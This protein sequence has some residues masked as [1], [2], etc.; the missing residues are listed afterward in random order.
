M[1]RKKIQV[2]WNEDGTK[3][4]CETCKGFYFLEEFHYKTK[5]EGCYQKY[6]EEYREANREVLAE[7]KKMQRQARKANK[8]KSKIQQNRE[9]REFLENA[10]NEGSCR[11]CSENEN[12]CLRFTE[13]N[14]A[15]L[16]EGIMA[17]SV[18]LTEIGLICLN[19]HAKEKHVLPQF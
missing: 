8:E 10:L 4:R 9:R 5:C 12:V 17:S 7:R 13:G 18:P 3:K 14:D 2:V 1:G 15:S 16:L 19:C 6:Q 11:F